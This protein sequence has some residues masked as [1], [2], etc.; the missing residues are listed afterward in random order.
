MTNYCKDVQIL[1]F[2]FPITDLDT[3]WAESRLINEDL[4]VANFLSEQR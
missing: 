4:R 2:I 1:S 3:S